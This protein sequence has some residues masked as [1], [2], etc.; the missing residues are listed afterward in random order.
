MLIFDQLKKN[1]PQLRLVAAGVLCGLFVL[2]GGLWWVQ[3][4]SRREFQ[5]HLEMQSFRTVRMPAVRGKILDRNGI[6]LAENLPTYNV[7]LYLDELRKDF[8]AAYVRE[9]A[10]ARLALRQKLEDEQRRLGRTLNKQEKKAFVLSAKARD[11]LRQRAR[12]EVASN[13]VFQIS[14]RL[15]TPVVLSSNTF[16]RHYGTRLALPFPI[17]TNLSPVQVAIFSEQCAGSTGADLEIQSTR[18]YPYTNT[19]AHVL[20]SLIRDESSQE[21]EDAFFSY[22]LP[23]YRGQLGIEYGYDRY[24]RGRA[25]VKSVVVNNVGYRQMEYIWQATE[26]GE[27]V[28]LTIDLQVQRK[29]ERALQING[30]LTRGAFVVMDVHTGDI[31]AMASSPTI[32]PNDSMQRMSAAESAWRTNSVLKPERNKAT[33]ENYAPGSIFKT[34][35]GLACPGRGYM[36]EH[37]LRV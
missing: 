34:L 28:V 31:I 5:A 22:R 10:N 30:P 20:G 16:Q 7:S 35:V 2:L 23:D 33:Q 26:P 19:A 14:Q 21:D 32:N 13:V 25:G 6:A 18:V 27:N 15:G 17:A 9:R 8:D 4:V 11:D 37:L 12:Y 36:P 3:I 1:D 29:A 24:L